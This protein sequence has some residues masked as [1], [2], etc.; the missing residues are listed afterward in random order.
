MDTKKLAQMLYPSVTETIEDL[1]LRFPKRE[2]TEGAKVTRMAPSPTGFIHLGN[3]YSALLDERLAHTSGGTLILRIEDTDD[4]R[5]VEGAEEVLLETLKYFGIEFDEGVLHDGEQGIYGPY[6]QSARKEIYSVV[7]KKLVEEGYAYPSFQTEEELEALRAR[8]EAEGALQTGYFGEWATDRLL[9]LEE[10][11]EKLKSGMPWVLRLKSRNLE[12]EGDLVQDGIR[13]EVRVRPNNL[14]SVLMKSDGIPPYHFAHVVDDHFMHITHIVRGEEYL[15]TF[16]L[17]IELFDILRWEKPVFCHTAHLM[18]LDDG[19]RRKLSKRKD[20]ELSLGFYKEVGYHPKAV[21]DYLLTL[22][23]SN[24]EE[25]RLENPLADA[26]EFPFSIEKV[27]GSGALFDIDKLNDISKNMLVTIDPR[28]LKDFLLEWAKEY[29][30]EAYEVLSKDEEKLVAILSI[31]RD[32]K[33]PRKDY[34]SASQ[35]FGQ[36]QFFY[37]EYFNVEDALPEKISN[38]EAKVLLDEY[39]QSYDHSLDASGWFQGVRDIATKYNYAVKMGD[40]KK[41]PENYKGSVADVSTLIR[42]ALTGR[43]NAPDIHAIQQILGCELTKKRIESFRNS[44]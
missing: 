21:I 4:K 13:G 6:Y 3:L 18:K 8:Q 1:E 44:L 20:P 30:P 39:L 10:I 19:N 38:E 24:F 36:I 5:R 41:H 33:N 11:E 16:P 40:Y 32:Q 2:L 25:W 23:N 9:T 29:N 27:G 14:D 35:M 28:E 15:S 7:A 43:Q 31:G 34:S 22:L 17:H 37:E 42:L 12:G 26:F